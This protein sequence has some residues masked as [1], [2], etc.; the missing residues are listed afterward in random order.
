MQCQFDKTFVADSPIM[1]GVLQQARRAAKVDTPVL[2]SGEPG[3]GRTMLAMEIHRESRRHKGPFVRFSAAEALSD[4]SLFGSVN[5]TANGALHRP[6]AIHRAEG[7]TLLIEEIAALWP[8]SQ[9]RLLRVMEMGAVAPLGASREQA[10]DV[11]VIATTSRN[12]ELEVQAGRFR[13]DLLHRI[14]VVPIRLPP[15]RMHRDDIPRCISSPELLT[16]LSTATAKCRRMSSRSS[17]PRQIRTS[18]YQE[19][20]PM[21]FPT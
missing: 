19:Y 20:R 3:T 5:D 11:R 14:G 7:G 15:L 13:Q 12:L 9:A 18:Y 2:I 4:G 1:R 8:T 17:R 21:A 10:V 6:G 16:L